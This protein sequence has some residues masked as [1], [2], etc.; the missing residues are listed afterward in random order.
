MDMFDLK[1]D[2]PSE[3]RGEFKPI[4]TNVPGM[5]IC[6]LFPRLAK[7]ADKFA[8][9]RSLADSDGGHDCYQCMTGRK[10]RD[11]VPPPGGWPDIWCLGFPSCRDPIPAH[12]QTFP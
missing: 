2:A 10:R 3:I 8:I 6:E 9:I 11:K 5:Q 12:P 4:S 1:P 7:I